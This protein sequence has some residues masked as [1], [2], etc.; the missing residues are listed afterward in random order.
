MSPVKTAWLLYSSI[1]TLTKIPRVQ[2]CL[3]RKRLQLNS[4][5]CRVFILVLSKD[6]TFLL[7]FFFFVTSFLVFWIPKWLLRRPLIKVADTSDKSIPIS[8]YTYVDWVKVTEIVWRLNRHK[9][10]GRNSDLSKRII[11]EREKT[12]SIKSGQACPSSYKEHSLFVYH[13]H[14]YVIRAV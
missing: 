1:F 9:N 11:V 4:H 5:A 12:L 6:T 8:L 7:S 2:L 13:S 10:D 14:D 3:R